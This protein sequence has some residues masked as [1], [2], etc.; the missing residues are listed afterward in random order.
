MARSFI[1]CLTDCLGRNYNFSGLPS[2]AMDGKKLQNS[3]FSLC[4]GICVLILGFVIVLGWS[5]L[6]LAA[7]LSLSTYLPQLSLVIVPARSFVTTFFLMV[8]TNP[9][10]DLVI[11]LI[12]GLIIRRFGWADWV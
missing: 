5:I 3:F 9:L 6:I 2:D 8:Y 4:K 11:I 10:I 12:G 7:L 1:G